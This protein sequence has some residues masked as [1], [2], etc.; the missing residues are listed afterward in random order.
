VSLSGMKFA[1]QKP[2][3]SVAHEQRFLSHSV[4]FRG[5]NTQQGLAGGNF[6]WLLTAGRNRREERNQRFQL[7][8]AEVLIGRARDITA[9][10]NVQGIFRLFALHCRLSGV[11]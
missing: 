4:E 3:L 2:F 11:D 9:T 5:S 7:L 1:L 6:C 10:Y 8:A